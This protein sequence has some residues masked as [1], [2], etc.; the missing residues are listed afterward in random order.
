MRRRERK[1]FPAELKAT[2]WLQLKGCEKLDDGEKSRLRQLRTS[3]L[4]TG[5][6]YNL[7]DGLRSILQMA[8]AEAAERELFWWCQW[9]SRSRIKEMV[10]VSRTLRDHWE[11]VTA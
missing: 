1:Q 9:A 3:H 4:Q 11:G 5:K 2:R 6:A 10:K 8:E 7:L